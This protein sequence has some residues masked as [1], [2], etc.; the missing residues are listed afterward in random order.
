M[1]LLQKWDLLDGKK[2]TLLEVVAA[3]GPSWPLL[4]VHA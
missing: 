2:K 3:V 1:V 4:L